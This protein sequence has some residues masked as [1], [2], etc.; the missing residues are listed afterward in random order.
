M[1]K[2]PDS[3]AELR[4]RLDALDA[5]LVALLNERAR[6]SLRVR[7]LK[8]GAELGV[9]DPRREAEILER[10]R[11]LNAGPLYDAQ[12]QELYAAILKVMKEVAPA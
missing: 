11:S 1:S 6:L 3:V 10:V 7:A 5:Q 4:A 2:L 12:L 8:A 9:F